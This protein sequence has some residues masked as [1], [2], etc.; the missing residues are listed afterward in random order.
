V[1]ESLLKKLKRFS[2]EHTIVLSIIGLIIGIFLFAIGTVGIFF[3]DMEISVISDIVDRIG[4]WYY[5][6]FALALILTFASRMSLKRLLSGW[7]PV[8]KK[9]YLKRKGN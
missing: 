6:A 9:S 8:I 4:Y 7:V 1:E 3:A 5:W 2:R